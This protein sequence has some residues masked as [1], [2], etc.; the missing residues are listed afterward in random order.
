MTYLSDARYTLRLW[1]RRPGVV[2][3]AA[4]SLALGVGA[5]TSMFSVIN[6]VQQYELDFADVDRLVVVWQT[7][8]ERGI[9]RASPSYEMVAALEEHGHSFEG[10]GFFQAGRDSLT[11]AGI[12]E[13][14]RIHAQPVD[15]NIFSVLGIA[16]HLGR[17]YVRADLAHLIKEKEVSPVVISH[18]TWQERLGGDPAVLG[19]TIRLDG[20]PR[21]VIGVMPESASIVPWVEDVALWTAND[22]SRV[23]E[24]RWMVPVGRL[25]PGVTLEQAQAEASGVTRRVLDAKGDD[26]AA[27]WGVQ[28]QPIHEAYFGGLETGLGFLLGAVSFVLLIGCANVANLLLAEGAERQKELALRASIGASRR[29]LVRQLLTESLMLG[30]L[31]GA[32]GSLF[33]IWGNRIFV[34]LVPADA[35]EILRDVYI[36]WRVLAFALALAV[37][38]GLL[39]GL[40]PA[41]RASRVDLNDILKDTG[42]SSTGSRMRGRSAL[43]VAEVALSMVLLVGAGLMMRGFLQEQSEIPGFDTRQLLTA[44]ILLG[45]PKYFEKI[46][47]DMNRVAPEST[48]FFERVLEGVR[49][50]P[51]VQSASVISHLPLSLE[52]HPFAVVG[53]PDPEPGRAPRADLN[54]VDANLFRT[55]GIPLLRGRTFDDRDRQSSAWVAAINKTFADRHFPDTNPIG[56]AIR[57]TF[58]GG[59]SGIPIEEPRPREIVGV[60]GNLKYPSFFEQAPA[61][62]Y[63]PYRQHLTEY[64]GGDHILHIRK[65]LIVRTA[66]DPT[67]L[68][69]QV[70]KV[71]EN[72]DA[73]QTA[74]DFMTMERRVASTPSVTQGR[75]LTQLFGIFGGLAILLAMVG[76]YGVM[77]FLVSQRYGEFG[78]RMAM[79]ASA[80]G[81]ISMLVGQAL[82]T[83]AIG[84]VLGL[85]G[86][87]ALSRLLNSVFWRLT[88]LDPVAFGSVTALMIAAA[89]LAAYLPARRVTRI[90]PQRALRHE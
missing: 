14:S 47:G 5:S 64:A 4:L 42:R 12:E 37:G 34:S 81:L 13:T 48:R 16:P 21:T 3:V 29:R 76:V 31:G 88:A 35:P 61:A 72:V 38:T 45:G 33:A 80:R 10:F 66:I 84:V 25:R 8:S 70:Q 40:L 15:V 85:A 58:S 24:A 49:A 62:V 20:V 30:L 56:Q 27:A 71:V 44:D 90:H 77:A 11:I 74:D 54:E 41:L 63:V 50:V 1:S 39:F 86:G 19:S 18:D 28:L 7:N 83:I 59:A 79:G 17:S 67:S 43:L 9:T 6:S 57:V 53:R 51:G 89:C 60:V 55:L 68:V 26:G 32:L 23:P 46:P 73:D 78:V 2:A 69:A 65:S 22:L 75:F 87:F 52:P 36:D 82:R